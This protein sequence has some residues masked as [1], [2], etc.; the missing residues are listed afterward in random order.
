MS[1]NEFYKIDLS[2]GTAAQLLDIC[3]RSSCNNAVIRCVAS[4]D[5]PAPAEADGTRANALLAIQADL[6]RSYAS[7][8][9][10]KVTDTQIAADADGHKCLRTVF[11]PAGL[12]LAIL[13]E[14]PQEAQ[15]RLDEAVRKVISGEPDPCKFDGNA[16]SIH[17]FDKDISKL[18]GLYA[19]LDEAI[20]GAGWHII[21]AH[22]DLIPAGDVNTLRVTAIYQPGKE[23]S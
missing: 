9:G 12:P 16:V 1:V 10:W 13:P 20:T 11:M 14:A 22:I 4:I 19:D 15:V 21:E 5:T 18:N 6:F 8:A 23:E 17:A 3:R 2:D 7:A